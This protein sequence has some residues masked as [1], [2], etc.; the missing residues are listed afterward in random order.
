[1][2]W[3]WVSLLSYAVVAVANISDKVLVEKYIKD[4]SIVVIFTGAVAAIIGLLMI[5]FV[6]LPSYPLSTLFRVLLAG[7]LLQA[8][9]LPY[10]RALETDDPSTVI[11]LGQAVPIFSLIFAWFFLQESL[12]PAQILGFVFILAGG[13]FVS[14]EKKGTFKLRKTFWLMM[15]ASLLFAASSVLFKGAVDEEN[16]MQTIAVESLGIGLGTLL[17]FLVPG[18]AKKTLNHMRKMPKAG[19]I[20]LSV[21]E[22]FYVTFRFLILIAFSLGPVS[23]VSVLSGSQPVFVIIYSVLL[24]IFFPSFFHE[25]LDR[26]TLVRKAG[27]FILMLFGLYCIYS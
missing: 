12:L 6:G 26:K 7:I 27:S 10:F 19:W 5:P 8:Y 23:M 13:V 20:S 16:V 17:L 15:L 14:L 21:S 3:I 24:T 4:S 18:F 22:T 9:L 25:D 11:P 1:M 2:S